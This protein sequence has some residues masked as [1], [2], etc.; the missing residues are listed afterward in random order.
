MTRD[1]NAPSA[2]FERR[3]FAELLEACH[4]AV[5]GVGTG[6][7][8][9]LRWSN[10]PGRRLKDFA[11]R[12]G[13]RAGFARRRFDAGEASEALADLVSRLDGLDRTYRLLGDE[14]SRELLVRLLAFRVLGPHHV[15]L[16]LSNASL[17]REC[18]RIGR[19]D[20]EPGETLPTPYG[21]DLRRYS[22]AARNGPV[23]LHAHPLGIY[24]F[25]R[26]EQYAYRHGAVSVE[27]AAGDV[28]VDGGGGW[29]DTVLWLADAVGPDGSVACVEFEAANL[30]I[31]RRNLEL[32]P[33]LAERAAVV[34]RALWSASG[35]ELEFAAAGPSTSIGAS[36]R[37]P[38]GGGVVRTIAIDDLVAERG[39]ERVDFVK[40]DVEGAE[41]PALRGAER[42]LR[43]F[44]PKLAVAAYHRDEDL[45]DLPA[46][47][48]GLGLGYELYLDHF[49]PGR[50][51]T[52]LFARPAA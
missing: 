33:K 43:R 30:R 11:A 32:N 7:D 51:E 38:A 5:S 50:D 52:V 40:L 49:T 12:L 26:L 41:L 24:A 48:D 46:W 29:G 35:E 15:A 2:D 36:D 42:T 17:W 13:A 22:V 10:P 34:E 6:W 47:I 31:L 45:V 37:T 44:R 3:L 14:R 19:R 28:A 18:A 23:R 16:P 8:V 21:I 20:A 4:S 1:R 9:S 25:F 39:L 27:P